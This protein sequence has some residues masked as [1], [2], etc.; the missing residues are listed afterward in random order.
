MNIKLTSASDKTLIDTIGAPFFNNISNSNSND[1]DF[2]LDG[3]SFKVG[4][5]HDK[6]VVFSNDKGSYIIFT[7]LSNDKVIVEFLED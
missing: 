7:K 2:E 6:G 3:K 1:F 5:A 4:V